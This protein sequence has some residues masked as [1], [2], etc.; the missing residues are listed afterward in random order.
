VKILS[1]NL[2]TG[3]AK[4]VYRP[5]I[6]AVLNCRATAQFV[7]TCLRTAQRKIQTFRNSTAF[8]ANAK[9]HRAG[10]INYYFFK[11]FKEV[12]RFW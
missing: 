5:D 3:W 1:Q 7:G 10:G 8:Y 4:F 12:F 11:R 2:P 9:L 6:H